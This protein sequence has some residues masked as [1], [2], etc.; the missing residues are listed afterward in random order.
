[1]SEIIEHNLYL[2]YGNTRGF[3]AASTFYLTNVQAASIA[4]KYEDMEKQATV[5]LHKLIEYNRKNRE[6]AGAD[7]TA[8]GI[9][10]SVKCLEIVLREA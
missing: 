4:G 5:A 8:N 6:I 2:H 1:M 9:P 10:Q 7:E 3:L